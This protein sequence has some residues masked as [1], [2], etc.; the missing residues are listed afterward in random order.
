MKGNK[1]GEEQSED[2]AIIGDP[3]EST[4]RKVEQGGEEAEGD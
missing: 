1:K 2:G 3:A 4:P